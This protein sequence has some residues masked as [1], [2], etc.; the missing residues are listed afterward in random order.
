MAGR[1]ARNLTPEIESILR[2]RIMVLDGAMGTMIQRH[3]LRA[4][5]SGRAIRQ[6]WPSPT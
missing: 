6:H 5:L 4:G 2:K 1:N 3:K